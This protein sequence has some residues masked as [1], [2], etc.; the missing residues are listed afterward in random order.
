MFG[1]LPTAIISPK[2]NSNCLKRT[3]LAHHFWQDQMLLLV[4]K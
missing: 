3:G 1:V 4:S 2:L